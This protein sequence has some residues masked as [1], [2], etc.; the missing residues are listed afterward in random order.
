[1]TR[2]AKKLWRMFNSITSIS[3][4]KKNQLKNE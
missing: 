1:L 2:M 4:S 3:W